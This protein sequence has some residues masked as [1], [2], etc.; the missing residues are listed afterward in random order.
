MEIKGITGLFY[1]KG[2]RINDLLLVN[3]NMTEGELKNNLAQLAENNNRIKSYESGGETYFI[4][5]D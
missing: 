1:E 4:L 3:E 5:S 2:Q